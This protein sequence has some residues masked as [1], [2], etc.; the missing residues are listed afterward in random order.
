MLLKQVAFLVHLLGTPVAAELNFFLFSSA[1]NLV[2][3]K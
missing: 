3:T 1:Y 2:C